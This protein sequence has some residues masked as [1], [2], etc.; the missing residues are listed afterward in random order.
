MKTICFILILISS[1]MADDP[2][3]RA[4]EF[5]LMHEGGYCHDEGWESNF[6]IC[7]RWYPKED[8]KNMKRERAIEI[9][10]KD[11][12]ERM[13]CNVQINYG[14]AL[15]IFDTAVMFGQPVAEKMLKESYYN[16]EAFIDL[17]IDRTALV[18]QNPQKTKFAKAW[19][20]RFY[21][22]MQEVYS[23]STKG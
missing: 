15:L 13:G 5:V 9:Y 17:R 22:L 19:M 2:F 6:G 10:R 11:Y 3:N 7:S 23:T 4:I 21:H 8:M 18:L 14:F 16:M 1:A 12:W 20:K